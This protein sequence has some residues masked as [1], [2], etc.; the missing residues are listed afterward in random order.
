[1]TKIFG[2]CMRGQIVS[3][4]KGLE[5]QCK[6]TGSVRFHQQEEFSEELLRS[7]EI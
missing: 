5:Q 4:K 3:K 6:I 7:T 2:S 1:M